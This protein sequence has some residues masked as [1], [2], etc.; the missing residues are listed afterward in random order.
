LILGVAALTGAVLRRFL[1]TG[2]AVALALT[3]LAVFAPVWDDAE[4][5]ETGALELTVLVLNL[6]ARNDDY[7]AVAALI[8]ERRPDLF[9]ALELTPVWAREL[10][11]VLEPYGYRHLEP[12]EG[13][14][15][16]G[17]YSRR[18]LSDRTTLFP[19]GAA[20]PIT[21][22]TV[23][24]RSRPIRLA[25]LHPRVPAGSGDA[26]RH[27]RLLHAAGDAVQAAG[28]SGIVM[29]DLNTTPW[30][31]RYK[32]L[33]E[34][35]GLED[36]REGRGLQTTWPSFLPTILRIPIDHVLVTP[37]LAA[38]ERE[39]GPEVGSDHLPVWVELALRVD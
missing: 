25:L 20:H 31:A 19:G 35:A 26:D 3:N 17:L 27:T 32:E 7:D 18:A 22:A 9:G 33:V 5:P 36:T 34:D 6:D 8:R 13:L 11:E 37:D 1:V 4:P 24:G 16:V 39:V 29:G 21:V 28:G 2:A 38:A 12:R 14:W 10:E 30:S 15:G 23:E